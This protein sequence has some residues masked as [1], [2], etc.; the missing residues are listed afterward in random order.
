MERADHEL[1]LSTGLMMRLLIIPYA[2]GILPVRLGK[3]FLGRVRDKR[4]IA[5]RSCKRTETESCPLRLATDRRTPVAT[6]HPE[7][8]LIL[9]RTLG[10]LYVR[11][12]GQGRSAEVV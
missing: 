1:T 11:F 12:R 8:T 6:L 7:H 10:D 2:H 3:L 4:V 5:G 9:R